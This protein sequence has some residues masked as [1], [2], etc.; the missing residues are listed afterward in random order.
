MLWLLTKTWNILISLYINIPVDHLH[1]DTEES[2]F[3]YTVFKS[4]LQKISSL[5][6]ESLTAL[7]FFL[8]L[9]KHVMLAYLGNKTQGC[10][11]YQQEALLQ[12]S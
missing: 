12:K 6:F 7:F 4:K 8:F 1:F 5:A 3:L 11:E 2:I 9:C 10:S